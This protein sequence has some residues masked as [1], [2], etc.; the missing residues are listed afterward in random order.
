MNKKHCKVISNYKSPFP[1]PLI[2]K[3]GDKLQIIEKE[4]EWSGWIWCISEKGAEGWVP[5][6]YLDIQGNSAQSLRDY[7]A[8]E[9][10][11]AVGEELLIEDQESGWIWASNK[12]GKKGWVPLDNVKITD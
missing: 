4:S 7:D 5:I 9:L 8:T 12:A 2:I 1:N 10:T 3:K 6:N 11:V